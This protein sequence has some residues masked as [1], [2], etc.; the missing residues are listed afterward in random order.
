MNTLDRGLAYLGWQGGTIW[1]VEIVLI[2]R[3]NT[4]CAGWEIHGAGH[5]IVERVGIM[6]DMLGVN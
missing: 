5:N 1:Q 2:Q 6:L 3:L 4:N